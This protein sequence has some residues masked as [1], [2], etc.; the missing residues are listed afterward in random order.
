MWRFRQL[1]SE[2]NWRVSV[3]VR[4][5]IEISKIL[6]DKWNKGAKMAPFIE[7]NAAE[8]STE[9]RSMDVHFRFFP[10]IC[11]FVSMTTQTNVWASLQLMAWIIHYLNWYHM[12]WCTRP[13]VV[14]RLC[15]D[16]LHYV[17]TRP[18]FFNVTFDTDGYLLRFIY[19]IALNGI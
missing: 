1:T 11:R 19:D 12:H 4:P 9:I 8:V 14:R 18:G 15:Y 13:T 5:F 6:D 10:I 2:W 17:I 7:V 3:C 16:N